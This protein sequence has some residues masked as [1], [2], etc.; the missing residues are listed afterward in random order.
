MSNGTDTR[1]GFIPHLRLAYDGGVIEAPV[2]IELPIKRGEH[3]PHT[4]IRDG[5]RVY[6]LPGGGELAA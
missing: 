5:K 6:A 1:E 3:L 2:K 4:K